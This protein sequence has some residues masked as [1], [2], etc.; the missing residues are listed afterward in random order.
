MKEGE[1][2]EEKV[3]TLI[4]EFEKARLERKK[5]RIL[6]KV[7][8]LF[9]VLITLSTFVVGIM[10]SQHEFVL[11]NSWLLFT[12]VWLVFSMT[13]SF[14]YGF[15]GMV[16]DSLEK[17]I[18][19]WCFLFSTLVSY[20]PFSIAFYLGEVFGPSALGALFSLLCGLLSGL[21]LV[22]LSWRFA[23]YFGTRLSTLLGEEIGE[24]RTIGSKVGNR[25]FVGF[26]IVTF[27]TIIIKVLS[28]P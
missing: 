22:L 25:V 26:G 12:M 6:S 9:Y 4:K 27:V 2:L 17:R 19:A 8:G 5:E 23:R 11:T 16:V 24:W 18:L 1:G 21:V 10:V 15:R 14:F 28:A 13:I 7:D 3:D 20:I